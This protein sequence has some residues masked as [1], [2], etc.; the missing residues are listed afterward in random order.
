LHDMAVSQDTMGGQHFSEDV[1][2]HRQESPGRQPHRY[3]ITGRKLGQ[4][5]NEGAKSIQISKR[6]L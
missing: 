1:R 2:L 5:L 4:K 6:A 3:E